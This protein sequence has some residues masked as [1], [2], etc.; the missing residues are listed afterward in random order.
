MN[1][2]PVQQSQDDRQETTPSAQVPERVEAQPAV[3]V[4]DSPALH[5]RSEPHFEES[6]LPEAPKISGDEVARPHNFPVPVAAVEQPQEQQ[7]QQQQQE[8]VPAP[9]PAEPITPQQPETAPQPEVPPAQPTPPPVQ[10]N[11]PVVPAPTQPQYSAPPAAPVQPQPGNG[12]GGTSGGGGGTSGGGGGTSGS[13]GENAG[14]NASIPSVRG[15]R[16]RDPDPEPLDDA[17]GSESAEESTSTEE[18]T[19]AEESTSTEETSK[20]SESETPDEQEVRTV[21]SIAEAR[22]ANITAREFIV[23]D[24]HSE[25][26][27]VRDLNKDKGA[28]LEIQIGN[29]IYGTKFE[30]EVSLLAFEFSD[31]AT[32]VI[33]HALS[34]AGDRGIGVS[35]SP[36]QQYVITRRVSVPKQV[37]Y[38]DGKGASIDVN[39]G[40][41]QDNP[42]STFEFVRGASGTTLKDFT[43]DLSDSK[44]TRG[45]AAVAVTDIAIIGITMKGLSYRGIELAADGGPLENIRV[46]KNRIENIVGEKETKGQV[47]SIS[48]N[49]ERNDPDDRFKD[50]ASPIWDRYVTDGTVSPNRYKNSNISIVGNYI[51]GG[52]YGIS[53]SGVSNSEIRDNQVTANTRNISMQNNC[54]DNVVEHNELSNSYSSSVHIAYNSNRNQVLNNT[55]FTEVSHGQGLLQAYQDSDANTFRGNSVTVVGEQQPSWLLYVGTDSDDNSFVN[56]TIDGGARRAVIGIESI[57][58]GRSTESNLNGAPTNLHSYMSNGTIESPVDQ[59]KVT[60][61]GG[62]GPLNNVT[63]KDN[64]FTPRNPATPLVYVGAEVTGGQVGNERIVG[65]INGVSLAD[66]TIVGAG[67]SELLK[68]HTGELPEIGAAKINFEND[69]VGEQKID[70]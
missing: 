46:E 50:S 7:P 27:F 58:D 61:G 40:A 21:A 60:Y 56:N 18:S 30:N 59:S 33:Q 32:E 15:D 29:A 37:K 52:Y 24:G 5:R 8:V 41:D 44:F 20:T 45:I 47:I 54:N 66:N 38:L 35:L 67:V 1:H 53:F 69:T 25:A 26:R 51:H 16:G 65:D 34:V 28:D 62:R 6:E 12:G 39:T 3:A 4:P 11:N 9:A 64:V 13:I 14:E 63:V 57:W 2:K 43:L 55:V 31:D 17:D 36:T 49:S 22:R 68:T 23:T 19:S 42:T 48:V 10:N 70:P